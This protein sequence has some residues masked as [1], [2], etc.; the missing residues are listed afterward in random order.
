MKQLLTI[1]E[2]AAEVGS[3]SRVYELI[4]A[5]QLRAVKIGHAT[6]IISQSLTEYIANLPEAAIAPRHRAVRGRTPNA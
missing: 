3:R 4:G 1:K 5:K 6:R 2:V